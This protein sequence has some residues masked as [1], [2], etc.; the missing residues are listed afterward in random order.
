[1]RALMIAECLPLAT[2]CVGV[3]VISVKPAA[4]RPARYST[5]LNAPAIQPT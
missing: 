5:V 4:A 1:L 3:T 2:S